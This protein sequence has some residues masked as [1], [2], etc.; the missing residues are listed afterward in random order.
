[1]RKVLVPVGFTGFEGAKPANGMPALY[2]ESCALYMMSGVSTT[3]IIKFITAD[4]TSCRYQTHNFL[5]RETKRNILQY[6]HRDDHTKAL[7]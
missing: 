4:T 2:L 3:D 1:M 5:S 6:V 7:V